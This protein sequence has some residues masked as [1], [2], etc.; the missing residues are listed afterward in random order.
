MKLAPFCLTLMLASAALAGCTENADDPSPLDS[1]VARPAVP[2]DITLQDLYANMLQAL[3]GNGRISH[4]TLTS[5]AESDLFEAFG[6]ANSRYTVEIWIDA[7]RE[8]ARRETR[9]EHLSAPPSR[10]VI[11]SGARWQVGGD[12][13]RSVQA[14]V[15]RDSASPLVSA[16]LECGNYIEESE[17]RLETDATFE[18]MTGL[19]AV[20]TEGNAPGHDENFFFTTRLYVDPG[21]WLPIAAI[22][23]AIADYGESNRFPFRG[24]TRYKHEYLGPAPSDHFF[25]PIDIAYSVENADSRLRVAHPDQ[26]PFWLGSA[27]AAAEGLPELHLYAT[28]FV[29][30]TGVPPDL[31]IEV[32]YASGD[33]DS[34][35]VAIRSFTTVGWESLLALGADAHWW[36]GLPNE[37]L[38]VGGQRVVIYRDERSGSTRYSAHMYFDT[39]VVEISTFAVNGSYNSR[40]GILNVAAG[41]LAYESAD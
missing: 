34:P 13:N 23:D 41:L 20:V 17:T 14:L 18:G 2:A 33:A 39:A 37:E 8:A 31:G 35:A 25:L 26:T 32:V 10:D 30:D 3:D 27:Y 11:L 24:E 21:T 7:G 40:E 36:S 19:V 29:G 5:R 38:T 22:T 6:M 28:N 15:C 4:L 1:A 16:V 12:E 9:Y